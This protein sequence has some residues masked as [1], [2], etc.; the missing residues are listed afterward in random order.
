[1]DNVALIIWSSNMAMDTQPFMI[2]PAINQTIH[3]IFSSVMFQ[4]ATFD[5][6]VCQNL[7]SMLVGSSHYHKS[8][9]FWCSPGVRLVLTHTH[10]WRPLLILTREGL[11][12]FAQDLI[13]DLS[14]SQ[15]QQAFH[16]ASRRQRGAATRRGSVIDVEELLWIGRSQEYHPNFCIQK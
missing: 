6:D 7:L 14:D 9:L 15:L 1:M 8:Q 4:L 3:R 2:F 12:I 5:I 10:I 13:K 11:R 16:V